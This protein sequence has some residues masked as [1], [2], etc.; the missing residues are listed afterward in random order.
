M[1]ILFIQWDSIGQRDLEEAFYQEGHSL[2]Y[3]SFSYKELYY[4]NFEMIE[5]ALIKLVELGKPDIIFTVNYFSF[6]TNF[7]SRHKLKYVSWIYDSPLDGMYF[8]EIMNPCNIVYTLDKEICFEF[9]KAGVNTIHYLPMAAN[10]D[11]LDKDTSILPF[12]YDVSFIGSLYLE[13]DIF[14]SGATFL[15]DYT[16]GYID[17]LVTTQLKVWGYNFIEKF[18][19]PILYD[20]RRVY[21]WIPMEGDLRSE[22]Y[23]YTQSVINPWI[24]GIERIDLLEAIAKYYGVDFFTFTHYKDFLLPN[25]RN[26]GFADYYEKAP[27]VFKQSRIN[28]NISYRGIKSAVPLRCFDI[29]GAGGF[30]L[31]N[32]QSGFLDLFIPEED[33]V[34]FEN[35]EDM[36]Q[37]IGYYLTHEKERQA[38]AKSGHDK[39][40]ACHTYRHRIREMLDF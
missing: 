21:P 8:E 13:K 2:I 17:A 36:L 40:A 19:D 14:A 4:G 26:H 39:V 24:T 30:L 5:K 25:L 11:R 6:V 9:R 27:Q 20:L 7:C 3:A 37:K 22:A 18:L 15:A 23:Y 16:E 10:I 29:M 34:F 28:M 1:R 31:S 12:I 33:F 32:F 38:I 35:K